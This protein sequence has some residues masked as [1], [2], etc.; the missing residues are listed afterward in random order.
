MPKATK[1]S[2]TN[3]RTFLSTMGAGAVAGAAGLAAVPALAVPVDP[4]HDA[5]TKHARAVANVR[6][7]HAQLVAAGRELEWRPVWD[8]IEVQCAAAKV[9]FETTPTTRAGERA[10]AK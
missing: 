7:V 3:R 8:A 6:Q 5:I 9:L 1:D 10:L 4:I 2:T